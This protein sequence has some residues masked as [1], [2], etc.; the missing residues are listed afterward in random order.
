MK[1]G[2]LKF[3]LMLLALFFALGLSW[4]LT[5]GIIWLI[6]VCFKLTFSLLTATGIWLV[7]LLVSSFFRG[8]REDK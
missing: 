3:I 5:C 1:I 2:M 4:A 7:L 8:R 6:C